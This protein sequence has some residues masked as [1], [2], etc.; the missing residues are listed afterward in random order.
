MDYQL[1]AIQYKNRD[2]LPKIIPLEEKLYINKQKLANLYN[3]RYNDSI[4]RTKASILTRFG[5]IFCLIEYKNTAPIAD[6]DRLITLP[7]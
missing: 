4:N 6:I 1:E 5:A 3:F 7:S 2:R